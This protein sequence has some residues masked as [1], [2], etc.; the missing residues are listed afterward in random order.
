M[1]ERMIKARTTRRPCDR[2]GSAKKDAD[3]RCDN[4]HA[5][6]RARMERANIARKRA[7]MDE[8]ISL[9]IALALPLGA[10]IGI[11]IGIF[12]EKIPFWLPIG[13]EIGLVCGILGG[14]VVAAHGKESSTRE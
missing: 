1:N 14:I 10:G 7:R 4:R 13:A 3:T 6:R 9:G 5:T 2:V 11:V 8:S 12:T